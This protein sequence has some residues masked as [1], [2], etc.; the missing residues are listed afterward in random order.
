MTTIAVIG[1]TGQIGRLVV[2]EAL[3]D[4]VAVRAQSRDAARARRALP[5]GAEVVAADPTDAE[6]L[7]P[8]LEGVDAVVLTHGTD[9]D[10]RGGRTFYDV[11]AAVIEVLPEGAHVALMTS[12]RTSEHPARYEFIAWKRRAERLLRASGRPYTIV[13]PGWFDYQGADERVI[14]L[15]QGDLVTG[16]RGV[17]KH[18]VAQVLLA[19]AHVASA[20][21]RTVEVFSKAGRPDA[22]VPAL[23]AAMRADDPEHPG[24][25]VLDELEVP[26]SDEPEA[27]RGDVEVLLGR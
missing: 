11:V 21:G 2:A 22:D 18:H 4:G 27:V 16:Q 17:S 10:G 20:P 26:L 24:R 6:A 15:R 19:G 13:R 7:R 9:V 5:E 3:T 8:V 12:M 23:V 1:A 25:A 14:D